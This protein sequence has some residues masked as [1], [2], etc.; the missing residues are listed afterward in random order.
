[1]DSNT[2][3]TVA[4]LT[5]WLD[6][7]YQSQLWHGAVAAAK[8]RGC[9]LL[10]LVGYA[11]PEQTMPTGPESIFGLAGRKDVDG[12]ML[13]AGPLS[14]WEG[15]L[16]LTQILSWLDGNTVASLGL[17]IPG[18]DSCIP[19]G[20]GVYAMVRHMAE[21]HSCR[22]IAF[23]GGP[24][25]NSDAKRRFA[26]YRMAL[27][28]LG[29]DYN[30]SLV[31][32]GGFYLEGGME[33][34]K[35]ILHKG[36]RIDAVVAAND[37]MAI[38]AIQVLEAHGMQVP[39]DVK[40]SGFDDTPEGRELKYPL[41]TVSNPTYK[42]ANLGLEVCLERLRNPAM[43]V[44]CLVVPTE[45]IVRR[46]CGC[47]GGGAFS[48]TAGSEALNELIEE[49]KSVIRSSASS[50]MGVYLHWLQDQL[51]VGNLL[52]AEECGHLVDELLEDM[53]TWASPGQISKALASLLRA[54][55]MVAE[56][57][58]GMQSKRVLRQDALI[59]E[60]HRTQKALLAQTEPAELI[61]TLMRSMTEW[62]PAGFRLFLLN[63]DFSPGDMGDLKTQ[64]FGYRVEVKNGT[65]TTLP[66]DEDLLP[67]E[68]VPG[69][70]WTGVP[71]EQGNMRFGVILFREWLQD[72]AF[73]EH[74]RIA[75]STAFAISWQLRSERKLRNSLHQL[76]IHDELTGLYNRRGLMDISRIL[77]QEAQREGKW[78]GVLYADL[79]GLKGINDGYGHAS[80]DLA[81]QTMGQALTQCFRG[82]DVMARLGGD[83]FAVVC[84]VPPDN[85]LEG[86]QARLHEILQNLSDQLG[87]PWRVAAS[88]GGSVWDPMGD[89]AWEKRLESEMSKADS[90]LYERK[91][92][93][94]KKEP[95]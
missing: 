73:V 53:A 68:F 41:T 80:G 67:A 65:V 63:E 15:P 87:K 54:E 38:G 31:A 11:S 55:R 43:D 50:S 28:D 27:E 89:P 45:P 83:E 37:T 34:M 49:A 84:L 7:W 1:M 16:A 2:G 66:E 48:D 29:L 82:S 78:L 69:E 58:Q 35:T 52:Q 20:S 70:V 21:K 17:E 92:D 59:R 13:S 46:S 74:L 72:E 26:D 44:S 6:G 22:N 79:D 14:F 81:I 91:M 12:V 30:P 25:Q 94:K 39:A 93:R 95:R 10:T 4:L 57:R 56:A 5:T 64:K 33:A 23:L 24:E 61:V 60:L 36:L 42:I 62:C 88:M 51:A 76:S 47:L 8:K 75:L 77:Y 90:Q 71:I 85:D 86:V 3:K 18:V 32:V 40:V 9:R 19:E